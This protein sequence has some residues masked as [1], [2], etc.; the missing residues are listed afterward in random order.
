MKNIYLLVF[1]VFGLLLVS[2]KDKDKDPKPLV[3]SV[4][5]VVSPAGAVKSMSVTAGGTIYTALPEADNSFV[6]GNLPP[7]Q[8]TVSFQTNPNYREPA[9]RLAEITANNQTDLGTIAIEKVVDTGSFSATLNGSSWNSPLPLGTLNS[10]SLIVTGTQ[11]NLNGN[12]EIITLMLPDFA[13]TGV[14][15][16]PA[17]ASATFTSVSLSGNMQNWNSSMGQCL[18]NISRFDS[19]NKQVSGTFSFIAT[20][21]DPNASGTKTVTN[22]TFSNVSFQ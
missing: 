4:R 1:A 9:K 17:D 3:G 22:G 10:N 8:Y 18:V 19:N 5:C 11:V 7:G 21:A 20:P 13:G 15:S 6:I 16:G 12:T 2:C 14:Y